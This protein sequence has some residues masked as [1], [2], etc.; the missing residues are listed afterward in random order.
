MRTEKG[1]QLTEVKQQNQAQKDKQT[2]V[3]E[4]ADVFHKQVE[5]ANEKLK[6]TYHTKDQMRESY[7]K[8]LYEWELYNDKVK[9][10]KTMRNQQNRLKQAQTEKQ[11]RINAKRAEFENRPNPYQKEVDTCEQLV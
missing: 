10:I 3:R 2:E 11:T 5:E 9:W 6:G 7:F 8:Q 1:E 4:R